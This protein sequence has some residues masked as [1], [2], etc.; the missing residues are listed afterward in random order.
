VDVDA[1]GSRRCL[2]LVTENKGGFVLNSS[3]VNR[4]TTITNTSGVQ[5]ATRR[6]S[7]LIV[8]DDQT[9]CTALR[10]RLQAEGYFVNVSASAAQAREG[11]GAGHDLVVISQS[12]ADA[13]AHNLL[14]ELKLRAPDMQFLVLS[15]RDQARAATEAV[16]AGAYC[17]VMKP[18]DV[19]QVTVLVARALESKR[20]ERELTASKLTAKPSGQGRFPELPAEGIDIDELVAHLV[21]QALMR[22]RGNKTRAAT[23]LGMTRDQIRYRIEKYAGL[24]KPATDTAQSFGASPTR[25]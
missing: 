14:R 12:L 9:A 10:E 22:T 2:L 13:D 1:W 19:E 16:T 17:F 25:Q 21:T 18:V 3:S 7:I 4:A 23:L 15:S 11:L 24:A 20:L 8:D 6:S 5:N